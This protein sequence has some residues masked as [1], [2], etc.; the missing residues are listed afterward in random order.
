MRR[1]VKILVGA[2]LCLVCSAALN[3]ILVCTSV[4]LA[5]PLDFQVIS[6]LALIAAA[7]YATYK[8]VEWLES[9]RSSRWEKRWWV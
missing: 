5:V 8:G 6:S 9:R 7:V 3:T 1:V 2:V 4:L